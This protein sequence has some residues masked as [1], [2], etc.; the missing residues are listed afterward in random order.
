M[1]SRD[2]QHL[3]NVTDLLLNSS[4][5]FFYVNDFFRYKLSPSIQDGPKMRPQTRGHNSVKS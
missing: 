1:L 4:E 3:W 2:L 5:T